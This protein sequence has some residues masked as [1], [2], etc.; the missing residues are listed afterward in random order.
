MT[1]LEWRRLSAAC[2]ILRTDK[3]LAKKWSRE[4]ARARARARARNRHKWYFAKRC[5]G[6]SSDTSSNSGTNPS[7]R[8]LH[9]KCLGQYPVSQY[10]MLQYPP[11]CYSA[12]VQCRYSSTISSILVF[13][14]FLNIVLNFPSRAMLSNAFIF[15]HFL[16]I[17]AIFGSKSMKF[18]CLV[19]SVTGTWPKAFRTRK[20]ILSAKR[21]RHVVKTRIFMHFQR[22]LIEDFRGFLLISRFSSVFVHGF[23][24]FQVAQCF[25]MRSF[26]CI[27]Y[28]SE[29]FSVQF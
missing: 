5:T 10:P 17:R 18:R 3:C 4:R 14:R 2:V 20:F 26:S 25:Q 9:P 23:E 1:R 24:R 12:V 7:T 21:Y 13:Q 15:L 11:Q 28:G 16:W 22:V 8:H 29:Q 27:F 19:Q 6:S